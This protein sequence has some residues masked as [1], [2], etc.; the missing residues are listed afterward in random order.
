MAFKF[1]GQ[2]VGYINCWRW[3][4]VRLSLFSHIIMITEILVTD[5]LLFP[6]LFP[7][8]KSQS[9]LAC[10]CVDESDDEDISLLSLSREGIFFARILYL[11]YMKSMWAWELTWRTR[12]QCL[13]WKD[14]N[15]LFTLIGEFFTMVGNSKWCQSMSDLNLV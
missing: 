4:N 6:C 14:I 2:Q 3:E 15:Q 8:H 1:K 12:G 10:S 13:Q 5:Y 11:E 9:L 7:L